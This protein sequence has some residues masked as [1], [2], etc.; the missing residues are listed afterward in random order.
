MLE[1]APSGLT[2]PGTLVVPPTQA[3]SANDF[4]L[5]KTA[6]RQISDKLWTAPFQSQAFGASLSS[7]TQ[8]FVERQKH[9][10]IR[11]QEIAVR[12]SHVHFA[13]I[14]GPVLVSFFAGGA[15]NLA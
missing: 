1:L 14:F 9:P 10:L 6:L 12:F 4:S 15:L 7:F 13:C 11:P 5:S 3:C 2:V 8:T